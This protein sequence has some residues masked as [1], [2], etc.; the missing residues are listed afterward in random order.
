ML[1]NIFID[2]GY[3]PEENTIELQLEVNLLLKNNKGKLISSQH[4]QISRK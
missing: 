2:L 4:R 3:L 1:P